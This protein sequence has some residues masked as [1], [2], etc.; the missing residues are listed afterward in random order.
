VSRDP[1]PATQCFNSLETNNQLRGGL[2]GPYPQ[3]S[4]NSCAGRESIRMM[5]ANIWWRKLIPL[6]GNTK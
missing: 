2:L 1:A 4:R 5:Q 3:S 6:E